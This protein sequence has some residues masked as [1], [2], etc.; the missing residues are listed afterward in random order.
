VTTRV[1]VGWRAERYLERI[2]EPLMPSA[3]QEAA[4]P[5]EL[6]HVELMKAV[7]ADAL[8]CIAGTGY[9]HTTWSAAVHLRLRTEAL[10]WVCSTDRSYVF[11]FER[12][13][14]VL[15]RDPRRLRRLAVALPQQ[16]WRVGWG[17]R[18]T[19][20]RLRACVD[21]AHASIEEADPLAHAQA[22]IDAAARERRHVV[23]EALAITPAVADLGSSE[24]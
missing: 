23:D 13:C 8:N 9:A 17:G 2:L 18:P 12:I 7:L 16:P 3:V 4:E 14:E 5:R 20:G 1:L 10:A 21:A 19:T 6:P 24:G 15:H 22:L 11:A